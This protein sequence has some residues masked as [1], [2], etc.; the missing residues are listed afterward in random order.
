MELW[1]ETALTLGAKLQAGSTNPAEVMTACKARYNQTAHCNACLAMDW[2]AKS[3]GDDSHLAGVPILIKDNIVTKDILTTCASGIL[4]NYLPTWDATAIQRLK[5]AGMVVLGKTNMDEFGMGSTSETSAMGA[6]KNPWNLR[7]VSGGSSGGSAAAVAAG[8][9][10]C[11]LGTD[12]GGSIR[13][14]AAHCGITGIKP[15]YGR[16]SRYGLIAYASSMDQIGVLARTA[17]DCAHVLNLIVGPD[18]WDAT[19]R[20]GKSVLPTGK[21]VKGLRIGIP[22]S[23][24]HRADQEMQDAIL[25]TAHTF[26]QLGASC[27]STIL[28]LVD[29]AVAAY[30]LLACAEAASNLSRFDGWKY[31]RRREGQDLQEQL[32]QTRTLGFGHEVKQRILLGNFALSAGYYEDYYRRALLAREEI[33]KAYRDLFA[34]YDLLLTPS[35]TGTAPKLGKSLTN[36]VQMYQEDCYT[37]GVNLAGLPA[38]GFPIG[39]AENGLPL[40]G[41]LIAPDMEEALL[42]QAVMAFQ[43]ETDFHNRY[44]EVIQP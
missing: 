16:V 10:P 5:N 30:Y 22:D 34:R 43:K 32:T 21:G 24:L 9:V 1:K 26:T 42:F 25:Q 2:N 36:R 14:P 12:T 4:E 7:H 19:C 18:P 41:Q 35:A 17:E 28:P 6:V 40:G 37:V 20:S 15:T 29:E 23:L 33:R 39:F 13:Q 44:P 27:E 8:I 31:G 38:I 3:Q 11:A